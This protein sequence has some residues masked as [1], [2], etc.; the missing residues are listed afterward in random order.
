MI[1]KWSQ[2]NVTIVHLYKCLAIMKHLRAM[3]ILKPFVDARLHYLCDHKELDTLLTLQ[4]EKTLNELMNANRPNS[5]IVWNKAAH[6]TNSPVSLQRREDEQNRRLAGVDGNHRLHFN[7]QNPF[8]NGPEKDRRRGQ[9]AE[10]DLP[11]DNLKND[12]LNANHLNV[13]QLKQQYQHPSQTPSQFRSTFSAVA[14]TINAYDDNLPYH[15]ILTATDNFNV[16]NVI[17]SGGF[18]IVYRGHWKNTTVAIKRLKDCGNFGQA[19]TELRV[20]S[21]FRID[22]IVPLY[23]VSVDGNEPCLIYQF[24]VNGSLDDRL[25][26]KRGSQPL[27]WNQRI[28]I[29]VGIARALNYLHTRKEKNQ[30]VHGDVN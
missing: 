19:I 30:L 17:G 18:G 6:P 23:G 3:S 4:N 26:C 8:I 16:A 15:E 14:S 25:Q 5:P 27:I 9:A 7:N 20:L 29:G 22:N 21:Q 28:K 11:N 24:M 2:S 13:N 10:R 12:K 1:G